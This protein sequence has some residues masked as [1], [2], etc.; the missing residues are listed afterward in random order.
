MQANVATSVAAS[1]KNQALNA[2]ALLSGIVVA[3]FTIY[4]LV[5]QSKL[6]KLQIAAHENDQ[7]LHTK[8]TK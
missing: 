5:H 6:L 1:H 8:P 2:I 7:T 3:G 4:Y